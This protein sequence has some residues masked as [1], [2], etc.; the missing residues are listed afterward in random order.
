MDE[1]KITVLY[2]EGAVEGTTY[3]GGRGLSMLIEVDGERTLFGTGL[4]PRYLA[5]NL[6]VA[7]VDPDSI[8][9]VVV[10][11]GHADHWGA[12][13]GL[14][15]QRDGPVK[16]F[17]PADAWGEKVFLGATGIYVP[18]EHREKVTRED[19]AG[20]TQLSEHLFLSLPMA[21][22]KG[23]GT[24]IFAVLVTKNG[25]VLISGCC[26]CGLDHIFEAVKDRF[27]AYPVGVLGGLHLG[28]RKDQL[29]DLYA[30]YL[31]TM[32]CRIL[33]LNHCT[34]VFGINRL[35]V[36]LGLKGVNDFY[37]GQ[38]VSFKIF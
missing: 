11:H 4:R 2:D 7:E 35:R 6:Y 9:R 24:E 8:T 20:W 14:L 10:S 34:G 31:Q 27:G 22:H 17:A 33:Y 16:V 23:N 5:N 36:T 19:V 38:S 29:A 25:P 30:Q 1:A 3:I 13:T 12:I 18:S 15:R 28:E 26:H 37:T 21:F 32:G